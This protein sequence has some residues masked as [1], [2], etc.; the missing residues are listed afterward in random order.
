LRGVPG[1]LRRLITRRRK[2]VADDLT[3]MV[4]IP[5]DEVT[6]LRGWVC[7]VAAIAVLYRRPAI[8]LWLLLLALVLD[9]VDGAL[10]RRQGTDSPQTDR[11]MDIFSEFLLCAAYLSGYVGWI[12]GALMALWVLPKAIWLGDYLARR[13]ALASATPA[14]RPADPPPSGAGLRGRSRA[15][16]TLLHSFPFVH[17]LTIVAFLQWVLRWEL[18]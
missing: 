16:L 15:F 6:R 18:S 10:A 11:A 7:F 14:A 13:L 8:T 5:A 3:P 12:S 2:R 9:S 4:S 1:D 17:V